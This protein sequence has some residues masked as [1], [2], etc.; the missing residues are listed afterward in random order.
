M[1]I[2]MVLEGLLIRLQG[3]ATVET[4]EEQ[5]GIHPKSQDNYCIH[6][7]LFL[8]RKSDVIYYC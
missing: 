5:A 1:L 8:E 4:L 3:K 6:G 7:A 2:T